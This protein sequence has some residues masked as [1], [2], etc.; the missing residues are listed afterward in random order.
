MISNRLKCIAKYTK[1]FNK[2]LDVG[3]DHG[4]LPIYAIEN[5]YCTKAIASDINEKPLIK[6]KENFLKH[7]LDIELIV[8]DGIPKT[9]SD[10]IVIA[11]MGAELIIKILE[12]TLKNA[13]N[14]KRLVLSPNTDYFIL[15]E[16]LNHKFN[17]ILEEVIYDKNHYYEVIVAEIG[18]SNYTYEELYFGPKLL[19]EKS[20]VFISKYKK[21]LKTLKN[22][23]PNITDEIKK[24]DI[25]KEIDM[26]EGIIYA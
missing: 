14:L 21:E 6:A 9:D 18:D 8:T 1:G 11:G 17:I 24:K 12:K 26:I 2:L 13:I 5:N 16:Y 3:S 22:I 20:E 7:N 4:L 23:Y 10:V 15:R 19:E 25:K